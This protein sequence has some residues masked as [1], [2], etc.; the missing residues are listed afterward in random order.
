VIP[1][2]DRTDY[3]AEAID[4]VAAQTV[5]PAEILVVADG[6]DHDLTSFVA[7]CPIPARVLSRPHGG[8]GAARNTG[9]DAATGTVLTYLDADDL[10]LPEKLE[11]QL[12]ALVRDPSLDMVFCGVEQFFS[13][14]LERP[15]IPKSSPA[16]DAEGLLPSTFLVRATAY[17]RVG[18]FR[19]GVVFG[20]FIDWYARAVD[21]GL[22]GC[23]I[24]EVH[25]RRRVHEH[26]AGVVLRE[27]RGDYVRVVKAVL[28]RRRRH[29]VART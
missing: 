28:D 23:T 29:P 22:H 12:A 9:S 13:P 7:S 21:I 25:V 20:E 5:A 1:V 3:L 27:Q 11:R 10:W 19:E 24:P 17:A 18:G 8:P 26:N 16:A 4:S 6:S 15:G 2:F 14:E